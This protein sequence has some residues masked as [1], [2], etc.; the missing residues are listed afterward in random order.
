MTIISGD[1]RDEE[2][3][4][5]EDEFDRYWDLNNA[6]DAT[7]KALED[8][9]ETQD[10]LTRGELQN[11]LKEQN[12]LLEQQ[13]VNY[14]NLRK[15]QEKEAGELKGKLLTFGVD[16]NADGSIAN[17]AEVTQEALNYYNNLIERRKSGKRS[18]N[19]NNNR[20][21]RN[22]SKKRNNSTCSSKTIKY[23]YTYIR[24]FNYSFK[25]K[26]TFCYKIK[27]IIVIK[28]LYRSTSY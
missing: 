25:L 14:Q 18:I 28:I 11:S 3:K 6:I 9:S 4:K 26:A 16:F 10:K 27:I 13:I 5:L 19:N 8:L 20:R 12:E 7:S 15:E 17:Y 23:R 2:L 22:K 24:I 1:E 21:K